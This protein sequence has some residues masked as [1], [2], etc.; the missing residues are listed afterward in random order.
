[1]DRPIKVDRV[2]STAEAVCEEWVQIVKQYQAALKAYGEAA[3]ELPGVPGT[4]FNRAW[5]LAESLRK[6]AKRL[7]AALLEHEHKHG[8]S[9]A[10]TH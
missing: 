8:C 1:M 9:I 7:R 10:R 4:E 3:A 6:E 5:M 2:R